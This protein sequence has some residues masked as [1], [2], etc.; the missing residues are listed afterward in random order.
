MIGFY[1]HAADFCDSHLKGSGGMGFR[2]P[3]NWGVRGERF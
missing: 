3:E 2:I 1:A